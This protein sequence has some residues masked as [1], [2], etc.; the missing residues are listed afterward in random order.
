[1]SLRV[2][3]RIANYLRLKKLCRTLINDY[4]DLTHED[5]KEIRESFEKIEQQEISD[6]EQPE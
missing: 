4:D 5:W 1:M 2:S 3:Y 6:A